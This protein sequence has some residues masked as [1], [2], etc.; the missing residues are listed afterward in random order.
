MF[1]ILYILESSISATQDELLS[2]LSFKLPSTA[3][4]IQS[5]DEVT[6]Y[7]ANGNIFS[8][9]GVKIIRFMISGT[10]WLDPRS[11]RIQFKLNNN[12][13]NHHLFP[14]NHL[15]HNFFQTSSNFSGWYS[16]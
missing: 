4:Y 5:R 3:N 1:T 16:N 7:P 13:Q 12:D 6:Y 15:P 10:Q 2:S 11:V 8:P 9:T 14:I